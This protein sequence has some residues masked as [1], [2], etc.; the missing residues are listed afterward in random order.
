MPKS[1]TISTTKPAFGKDK[2]QPTSTPLV[3]LESEEVVEV[4]QL[5][6]KN[7]DKKKEVTARLLQT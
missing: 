4:E 5:K 1:T 6:K 2:E 7:K 3:E